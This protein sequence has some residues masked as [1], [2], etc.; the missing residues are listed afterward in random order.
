MEAD[1]EVFWKPIS[2]FSGPLWDGQVSI[3]ERGLRRT[4]APDYP[5]KRLLCFGDSITFGFGVSDDESYPA[6]LG[7]LLRARG[8]EVRNAGVTGYTSY[9]TRRWLRRQLTFQRV[10]HVSLLIGWNDGTARPIT[11]AEFAERIAF[12]SGRADETLRNLAIYRLM[13][14]VWLRRGLPAPGEQAVPKIAR[15]PLTHYSAN[16]EAFVKEVRD[17]GATPH[18]IALPSRLI[19]GGKPAH[20]EYSAVLASVAQR[21]SVPLYD[22]GVLAG[23]SPKIATTGNAAYFLDSLHMT[24]EG[25]RV[26]ASLLAQQMD[27]VLR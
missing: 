9:Q 23:G 14:S 5:S 13:K 21:L 25:N 17:A 24:P 7:T 11:D 1:P 19:P 3:D 10:D 8:I 18:F 15:V 22:V 12:S 2:G 16:L 26:M 20:T 4:P 6:A 27:S